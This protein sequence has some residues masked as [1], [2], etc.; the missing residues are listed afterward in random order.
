MELKLK[1]GYAELFELVKQLPAS[2][3]FQLKSD[4]A[5][6]TLP[7]RKTEE[8]TA[9]RTLLLKGPVMSEEQYQQ[10]LQT[11]NWMNQWRTSHSA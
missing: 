5:E 6:R 11:R 9:F 4:L 10:F 3:F 8:K 2:Q 7:A 1:I